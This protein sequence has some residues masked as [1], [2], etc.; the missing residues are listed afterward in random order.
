MDPATIRRLVR[1]AENAAARRL[2][3]WRV[4]AAFWRA[5]R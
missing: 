5:F 2:A 1:T 3:Q 4:E